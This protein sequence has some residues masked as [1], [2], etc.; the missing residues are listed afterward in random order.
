LIPLVNP[1]EPRAQWCV[2][3]DDKEQTMRKLFAGKTA[4]AIE[5]TD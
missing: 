1:F 3:I 5:E 2:A 4:G